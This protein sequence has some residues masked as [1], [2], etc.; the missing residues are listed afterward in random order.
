MFVDYGNETTV[1]QRGDHIKIHI[2]ESIG[3]GYHVAEVLVIA[4]LLDGR[5][6]A[7]CKVNRTYQNG[8]IKPPTLTT[9]LTIPV[10]CK[11]VWEF[12]KESKHEYTRSSYTRSI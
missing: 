10:Y 11:E 3:G 4:T 6:F 5:E 7:V 8:E 9:S 1:L 2:Q 12:I